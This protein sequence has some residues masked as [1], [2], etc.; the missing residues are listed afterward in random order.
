MSVEEQLS[1][2]NGVSFYLLNL[3]ILSMW[4]SNN[5]VYQA[6]FEHETAVG[7]INPAKFIHLIAILTYWQ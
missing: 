4:M 2:H 5:G 3:N 6:T 7:A 1:E